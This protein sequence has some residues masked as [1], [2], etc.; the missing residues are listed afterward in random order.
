[1]RVAAR[2]IGATLLACGALD[3]GLTDAYFAIGLYHYYANVA[4]R[5][6]KIQRWLLLLPGGDRVEGGLA[7]MLRARATGQLVRSEAD[8][9]L[10]LI[11]LWYEKEPERALELIRE[12]RARH[13]R[14]PH[15]WRQPPRSKTCISMM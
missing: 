14:N 12:L 10:H 3:P 5:A 15:F 2:L 4:P 8:Y 7:E 9:Q 6:L 11:Y 13:P 1:M